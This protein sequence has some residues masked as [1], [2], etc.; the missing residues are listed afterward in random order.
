MKALAFAIVLI[1]GIAY[2]PEVKLLIVPELT[3]NRIS[4]YDLSLLLKP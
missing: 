2:V 4:A 1:A 3:Q